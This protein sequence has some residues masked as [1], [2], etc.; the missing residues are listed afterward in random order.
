MLLSPFFINQNTTSML[1]V[2]GVYGKTT[3]IVRIPTSSGRSWLQIEFKRGRLGLGRSNQ[4]A[5][6]STSDP[7]EQAIIEDSS[8]FGGMIKLISVYRNGGESVPAPLETAKPEAAEVDKTIVTEVTT[9]E[10]AVA[11]LKSKGAKAT[12]LRDDEA[13]KKFADK[14]GVSFPN[15]Y[16]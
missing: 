2:Y 13:I 9:K 6:Y 3:A 1:K 14:I 7:T 4:A 15:L 12:Q 8:M 10:Q 16:E 11:Y 5:T